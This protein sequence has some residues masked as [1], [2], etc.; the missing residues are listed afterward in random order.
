M[1][2]LRRPLDRLQMPHPRHSVDHAVPLL[3]MPLCTC[4]HPCACVAVP[5]TMAQITV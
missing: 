5:G 4:F 1:E 3:P 2:V